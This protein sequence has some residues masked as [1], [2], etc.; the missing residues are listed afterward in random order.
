ME[1]LM[2]A[3]VAPRL[4]ALLLLALTTS[5]AR[6][7]RSDLGTIHFP[8][9]GDLEAQ[10]AFT[11][12]VLLLHSF[13]YEDAA[14]AFRR[15]QE[16]D[17]GF[18]LA[19]WGEAMTYNH[20]VW[21]E[22]D[23]AAAVAALERL[24]PTPAAR[25]ERA[26]TEREARYLDA[27]EILYGEGP[28]EERDDHYADAMRRLHADYADD[29]EA[30]V[31]YSL[32]L[33]GTAHG[34]RDFPTYMMAAATVDPVFEANPDHPG[35]AH[36]L[37]HSFDDPIHAPLG[38][39]AAVAYSTIAP[40][41]A[42][43]QHMTSHIFVARGMWDAVVGANEVAR[44][45]ANDR[46]AGLGRRPGVCGHYTAWLEYGYLQQGRFDAANGVLSDCAERLDAE[47]NPSEQAYYGSMMVMYAVDTEDWSAL[48]EFRR[49]VPGVSAGLLTWMDGYRALL[50]ADEQAAR[51]ALGE[52]DDT[53]APMM[54]AAV[55]ELQGLVE[56]R[57]GGSV[58]SGLALLR[59]AAALEES[60]PYEFGPPRIPLPTFEALGDGLLAAGQ[61][62]EA[63]TA[64]RAQLART[65]G[66]ARSVTGLAAAAEASGNHTLAAEM[67]ASLAGAWAATDQQDDRR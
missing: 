3:H 1:Q 36:M 53:R 63:I 16:I 40:G 9:S 65:P 57:W 61:P 30:A 14:T 44:D 60:L 47:P 29:H 6:A 43:A 15:A 54:K 45:V 62:A 21:M 51:A 49:G 27:V 23:R 17:S 2:K 5:E 22:Q 59:E 33:L 37:I 64:Y 10:G 52:I 26:P 38:L 32:A 50:E 12:G 55:L 11:E 46:Q 4:L 34:G 25:R 7:Q 31:F 41:A 39:P 8:N 20:P 42:H 24:A 13:E 67:R 56:M 58:D 28:K 35:A 18:A 48:E 19:Y 66:R